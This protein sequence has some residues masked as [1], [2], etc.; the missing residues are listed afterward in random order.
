MSAV[1]SKTKPLNEI[2]KHKK[3]EI[4]ENGINLII[5]PL[6]SRV[7]FFFNHFRVHLKKY[8]IRPLNLSVTGADTAGS[9]KLER[10]LTQ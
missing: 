1:L 2:R 4:K 9:R 3:F 6:K 5:C 7:F 10:K 8:E